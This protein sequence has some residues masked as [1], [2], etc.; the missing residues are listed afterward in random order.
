[1][2]VENPTDSHFS[3]EYRL[4]ATATQDD[5][6]TDV[7]VAK[8]QKTADG[9]SLYRIDVTDIITRMYNQNKRYLHFVGGAS[10]CRHAQTC[11]NA[12]LTG[13]AH[14]QIVNV[15][16]D[17]SLSAQQQLFPDHALENECG[18][19]SWNFELAPKL[20]VISQLQPVLRCQALRRVLDDRLG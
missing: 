5:T 11:V 14:I 20:S 13:K 7:D 6:C 16:L 17:R 8:R 1:M 10:W 12:T 19:T 15:T 3:V 2:H 18:N 4:C 9:Q